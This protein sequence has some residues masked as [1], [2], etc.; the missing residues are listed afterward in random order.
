MQIHQIR[1]RNQQLVDQRF[2]KP[3]NVVEWLGAVQAQQLEMAKLAI[4]LRTKNGTLDQVNKAIDQGKI[5][6]THV[7][8]PT[9]HIVSAHDIRWILQLSYR[10]LKQAYRTLEKASGLISEG[11]TW[12]K[13]LDKLAQLLYGQH[14]TRPQITDYF[15]Q[16][17]GNLH[18]HFMTTLLQEAEIEGIVC[19]GKQQNGQHTYTLMDDWIPQQVLPSHEEALVLLARKYFQSHGPARFNDFLWWSGLTI[20]EARKAIHLAGN[21]LQRQTLPNDEFYMTAH[22]TDRK[23]TNKQL[24]LLPSYD[25][26][27][28]AYNNRNDVILPEDAPKAFTKNGIFFPLILENGRAIGNWKLENKRTISP[29]CTFFNMEQQPDSNRLS[30]AIAQFQQHFTTSKL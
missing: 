16:E 25:E 12:T 3:E 27:I 18:P 5:V 14:L 20:T 26:Y 1:L 17:M 7:L 2:Q 6:R 21:E 4:A 30:Q 24:L 15:K 9:W 23:V 29:I 10:K 13:H 8:R 22:E 19:S 28:I 11:Q